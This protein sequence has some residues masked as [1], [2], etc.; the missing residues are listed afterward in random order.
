MTDYQ[1]IYRSHP[2]EYDQLVRA[3]DAQG[4][5]EA[6]LKLQ[7]PL[8][9]ARVVEVGAGTGRITRLLLESGAAHVTA[10]E[11]EPAMLEIAKDSIEDDRVRFEVADGRS[12]PL[13]A[14]IADLAIAGWVFGHFRSWMPQWKSEIGRAL[15][16]LDRVTKLGGSA[17]IIETLGTGFETPRAPTEALAEYYD[18]LENERGFRRQAIRTD[19]RFASVEEAARVTG[20]FFGQAFKE[21]VQKEGW[22]TVPECTGLWHRVLR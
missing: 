19:Y 8:S 21:R 5:L 16:E 17:V 12:L 3:E 15:D 7:C 4:N 18:W 14:N 6:A 2:K 1:R 20:F 9:G 11:V 22:R 13:E 10:T